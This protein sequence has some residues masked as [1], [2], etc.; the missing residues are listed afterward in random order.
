MLLCDEP[1]DRSGV[2]AL[3]LSPPPKPSGI[4]LLRSSTRNEGC[5]GGWV[6]MVSR[7]LPEDLRRAK[8]LG[9]LIGMWGIC[10]M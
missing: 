10:S 9:S 7:R 1:D 3:N 8:P 5:A 6:S 4:L 2:L